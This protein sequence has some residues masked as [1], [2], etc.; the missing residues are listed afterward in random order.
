MTQ[1]TAYMQQVEFTGPLG[2]LVALAIVIGV[3]IT[4][5][6]GLQWLWQAFG[7]P[8]RDRIYRARVGRAELE[9][10][11]FWKSFFD[12]RKEHL[13]LILNDRRECIY[14]STGLERAWET[15]FS[16]VSGRK[17]HRLH[18]ESTLKR[19][20]DK[21]KESYEMQSPLV[22]PITIIPNGHEVE[23]L[24]KGEPYV[25]RNKVK[26]FVLSIQPM[27]ASNVRQI[28]QNE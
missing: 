17:W 13:I 8:L 24:V 23:F 11:E 1:Y 28:A 5:I 22:H 20:L 4:A 9:F 25:T 26:Y 19:Y 15:S 2:L 7:L 27:A 18:K 21:L 14:I 16:L 3:V 12:H 10:L 6:K